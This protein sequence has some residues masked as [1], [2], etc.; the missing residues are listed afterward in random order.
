MSVAAA[1]DLLFRLAFLAPTSW[2][3]SGN[4]SWSARNDLFSQY[5]CSEYLSGS[6]RRLIG[7]VV[8]KEAYLH[9]SVQ[10]LLFHHWSVWNFGL[11]IV[12][13]MPTVTPETPPS[14]SRLPPTA[15]K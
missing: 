3:L 4:L 10:W 5:L 9:V 1:E 12:I 15:E 2:Y 7:G 14:P 8:E 11:K 6:I 13:L